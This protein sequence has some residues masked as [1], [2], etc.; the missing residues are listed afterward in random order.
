MDTADNDCDG[1]VDGADPDCTCGDPDGD[2][3][4]CTVDCDNADPNVNPGAV[5]VCDDGV[6]NDC[7]P[8][9]AD[10][11]DLDGDGYDCSVDCDDANAAVHPG[12]PEVC[13]DGIDNDCLAETPDLF[14]LDGDSYACDVDCDDGDGAVH[15]GAVETTCDGIDNDC[16]MLTVDLADGD[17]DS[18]GC[19]DQSVRGGAVSSWLASDGE[20]TIVNNTFVQNSMP[21]GVGGAVWFDGTLA[22]V[23]SRFLNNIVVANGAGAGGGVDITLFSGEVV[24][25]DLFGNAGGDLYD[26][27]ASTATLAD[28]FFV[29]PIF[30]SS[31]TGNYQLADGSPFIDAALAGPAPSTDVDGFIRPFD[32]DGDG[33]ALPDLGAFESPSGEVFGLVFVGPDQ[34]SWE[35]RDGE[36]FFNV[37]RGDMERLIVSGNY[38]QALWRPHTGHFCRLDAN[39][40]IPLTDAFVPPAGDLVYYLVTLTNSRK[41]FEGS[42]GDDTDGRLR[43]NAFPCE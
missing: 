16:S 37:Y 29:D 32:G 4:D 39:T 28:N 5:E 1:L 25:N 40:D 21:K 7:N 41:S 36:R 26:G 22:L 43:F 11:G 42:L 34:L 12:A 23:P 24:R 19:A 13:A 8:A 35:V 10:L 15:P 33:T 3:Y 38:T 27:G 17:G 18:I 9:T 6:D 2:G 31:S 30:K 14:D 20:L